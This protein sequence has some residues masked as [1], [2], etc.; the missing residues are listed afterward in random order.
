ML[1]IKP[2][3]LGKKSGRMYCLGCKDYIDNFKSQEVKW[4][5]K[6]LEKNQIVLIV[7]PTNQDFKNKNTTIKI[8]QRQNNRQS[9]TFKKQK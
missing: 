5:I 3:K 8:I 1:E 9:F 4:Q 2:I 7:D 6:C